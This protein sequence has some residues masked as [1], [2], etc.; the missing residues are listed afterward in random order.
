MKGDSAGLGFNLGP[1]RAPA[2]LAASSA[3]PSVQTHPSSRGSRYPFTVRDT[4]VLLHPPCGGEPV[5]LSGP[6][7]SGL[8]DVSPVYRPSLS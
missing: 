4:V 6:I 7:L 3:H 5:Y 8:T 1:E 2:V